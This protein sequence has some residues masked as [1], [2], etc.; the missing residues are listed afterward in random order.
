LIIQYIERLRT[1]HLSESNESAYRVYYLL[2]NLISPDD[3][4]IRTKNILHRQDNAPL[5]RKDSSGQ[6]CR[7]KGIY[8]LHDRKSERL[9]TTR[10]GQ[11]HEIQE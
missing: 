2:K 7:D 1:I 9:G 5:R 8:K 3:R 10:A 11:R 6:R 4:F